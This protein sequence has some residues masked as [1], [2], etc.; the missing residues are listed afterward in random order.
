LVLARAG[1]RLREDETVIHF[2][3]MAVDD[4]SSDQRRKIFAIYLWLL[5]TLDQPPV[6]SV[7]EAP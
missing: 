4:A 1:G 6:E 2:L 5:A 7:S 3:N